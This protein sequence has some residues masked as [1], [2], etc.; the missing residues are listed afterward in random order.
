MSDN[1]F[2]IYNTIV[3]SDKLLN[4][5]DLPIFNAISLNNTQI[6][7][8]FNVIE[9]QVLTW[10]GIE[11]IPTSVIGITGASG[12]TGPDGIIG[13]TGTIGYTGKIGN[14]GSLGIGPTGPIGSQGINGNTGAIGV[15]GNTITGPK[16]ALQI[17]FTGPDGIN[18]IGPTGF[19]LTGI[20]GPGNNITLEWLSLKKSVGQTQVGISYDVYITWT[21][22]GTIPFIQPE[23][24][25]QESGVYLFNIS[26]FVNA[27]TGSST[28]VTAISIVNSS[29]IQ[30]S[31]ICEIYSF[32][33]EKQSTGGYLTTIVKPLS[34]GQYKI[35]TDSI[36]SVGSIS[37]Y[38][39]S[40][41]H[42]CS[43]SIVRLV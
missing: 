9:G 5:S 14:S 18:V 28:P 42:T 20:T 27:M 17:G 33:G 8:L 19:S 34:T 37:T 1:Y 23:F 31:S 30:Q 41:S 12:L 43:C 29:N 6:G 13:Y 10:N 3:P 40:D 2:G 16:G 36:L 25:L 4:T 26:M 22:D 7:T 15:I 38:I 35:R 39:G 32:G 24:T 21:S 11:W